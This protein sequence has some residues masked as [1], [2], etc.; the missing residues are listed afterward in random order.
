M[1]VSKIE[2]DRERRNKE[3]PLHIGIM[4]I[5]L[6]NDFF[7][8]FPTIC[9]YEVVVPPLTYAVLNPPKQCSVTRAENGNIRTL[10]IYFRNPL[11]ITCA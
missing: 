3:N 8:L 4:N 5:K 11:A 9:R 10:H 1:I 6:K 7:L 2:D